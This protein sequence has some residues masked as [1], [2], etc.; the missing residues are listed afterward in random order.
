MVAGLRRTRPE[1]AR[2]RLCEQPAIT[3]ARDSVLALRGSGAVGW[4]LLSRYLAPPWDELP[5]VHLDI[6]IANR[7][8][9]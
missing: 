3:A 2:S 4:S 8:R 6:S 5:C 1:R 9:T 7:R